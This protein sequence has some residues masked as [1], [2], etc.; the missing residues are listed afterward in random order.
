[1]RA[2]EED[3]NEIK[4]SLDDWIFAA[5]DYDSTRQTFFPR[6]IG[7]SARFPLEYDY[8]RA[9]RGRLDM[10]SIKDLSLK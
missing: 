10:S 5:G 8:Y 2:L 3:V 1:M 7:N 6:I 4:T 9:E